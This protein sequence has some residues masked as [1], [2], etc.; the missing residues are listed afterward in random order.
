[1]DF[2]K[3][4]SNGLFELD[5]TIALYLVMVRMLDALTRQKKCILNNGNFGYYDLYYDFVSQILDVKRYEIG[6]IEPQDLKFKP[7]LE[8]W[9][10]FE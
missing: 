8:S 9:L 4:N 1:M 2:E 6:L 3:I 5:D 10:D 7:V